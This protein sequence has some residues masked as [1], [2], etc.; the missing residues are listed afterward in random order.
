V[1]ENAI[2]LIAELV[3]PEKAVRYRSAL[4]TLISSTVEILV[5]S[6]PT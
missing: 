1:I 6:Q 3:L 4:Q 5:R 2:L